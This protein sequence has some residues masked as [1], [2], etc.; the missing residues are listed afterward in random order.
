MFQLL[1]FKP[2]VA[3]AIWPYIALAPIAYLGGLSSPLRIL[4]ASKAVMEAALYSN[5]E[6]QPDSPF[7]RIF[8]D[9]AC[10][11]F[12]GLICKNVLDAVM[13]FSENQLNS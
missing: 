13:G 5:V 2:E 6:L 9:T 3:K 8:A 12:P 10:R 4:A 7:N 11:A 1:A